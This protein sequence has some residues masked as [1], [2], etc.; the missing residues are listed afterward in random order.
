MEAALRASAEVDDAALRKLADARAQ[1]VEDALAGKGV[2]PDRLF[3]VASR[4]GVKGSGAAEPGSHGAT[5]LTR[6]DLALRGF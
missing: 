4:I 1:A 6:V 5:A 2:A 3:L